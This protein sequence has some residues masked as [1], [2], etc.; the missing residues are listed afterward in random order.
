MSGPP[1][2]LH[3]RPMTARVRNIAPRRTLNGK[4]DA[5]CRLCGEAIYVLW[6]SDEDPEGRCVEGAAVVTECCQA[7]S[8]ARE[9]AALLDYLDR[10]AAR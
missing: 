6:I 4:F 9:R 10:Q 2:P 7:M 1:I 5:R 3:G 8:V